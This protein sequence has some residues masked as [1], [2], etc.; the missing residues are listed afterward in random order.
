[1]STS[2]QGSCSSPELLSQSSDDTA[3]SVEGQTLIHKGPRL[4]AWRRDSEGPANA[5]LRRVADRKRTIDQATR[6]DHAVEGEVERLIHEG[7][8]QAA[9]RRDSDLT[10]MVV[11]GER[12]IQ[13]GKRLVEE[14]HLDEARQAF[15]IQ[16][17]YGKH[18]TGLHHLLSA[19][20]ELERDGR[21]VRAL[22]E[23]IDR[24]LDRADD[25]KMAVDQATRSEAAAAG[26]ENAWRGR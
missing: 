3:G 5:A 20:V 2:R 22:R 15:A 25:L 9:W 4:A 19:V 17:A 1:M 11:R 21:E 10:D 7:Q 18:S 13:E 12:L 26:K 6:S 23:Q 16:E 8:R 14:Q 24:Y